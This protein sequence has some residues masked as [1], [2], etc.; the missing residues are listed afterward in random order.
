MIH[1]NLQQACEIIAGHLIGEPHKEFTGVSIDTRTL[2]P[3]NLFI[4]L[5]GKQVDGHD[6]IAQAL[7]KGAAAALVTHQISV[8]LPQLIVFDPVIA[9]GKLARA[10]RQKFKIP[11]IAITGSNGKTTTKNMVHAIFVQM[12]NSN[13]QSVL[14]TQG[15]LNNHLGVPLTLCQLQETH[16][17]AVIEMGMN[18]FSEIDYLT[19]ITLPTTALIT[20]ALPCHLEGV[21]GTLAGVAK[22]KGEIFNGLAPDGVAIINA[23]DVFAEYWRESIGNKK[24]ITF[25]LNNYADVNGV[26]RANGFRLQYNESYTD[27]QLQLLGQHNVNNAVAA[28]AAT[29]INGASLNEIK[30]ALENLLPAPGR[31][32]AKK[33]RSDTMIIDDTYNA[34]PLSLRA[35]LQT[36]A[37][38]AGTKI[39][40]LGEMK[41]LGQESAQFHAE[42][43]DTAR[44]LRMDYLFAIGEMTKHTV[45]AFGKNAYYFD[46]HTSLIQALETY[47]QPNTTILIKGSRS[48][49]MEQVVNA[50][51]DMSKAKVS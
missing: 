19:N 35:A 4:A 37:M 7:A 48:L 18:H 27:I 20:N 40:V 26:L 21:G 41:E 29:I 51:L 13:K 34:N 33:G 16:R 45:Q 1:F 8:H 24:Y 3:G 44:K 25:G 10:W 28:S 50:L 47:L 39:V 38:Y 32:E 6:F 22:A 49:K 30:L 9:L 11:V 14:A 36:I 43:G 12:N 5:K 23:D 42:S 31:M 46:N 15:N 17:Q 2:Q